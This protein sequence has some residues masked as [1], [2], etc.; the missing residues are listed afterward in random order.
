MENNNV[1]LIAVDPS[2]VKAGIVIFEHKVPTAIYPIKEQ[3]GGNRLQRLAEKFLKILEKERPNVLA[4]ETQFI[5]FIS[6]G[7]VLK[8]SESRGLFEGVFIVYCLQNNIYPLI[9]EISP[10]AA[11]Y[12][13]GVPKEIK[14]KE[15]KLAVREAVLKMF[16]HIQTKNQDIIDGVSIGLAALKK[17]NL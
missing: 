12:A 14:R 4:I 15:S 7:I 13:V 9:I 10:L 5:N 8:L 3:N 6:G 11:K 16:P 2:I 17:L 1:R